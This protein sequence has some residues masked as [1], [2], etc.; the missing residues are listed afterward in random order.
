MSSLNITF[1]AAIRWGVGAVF[2]LAG[3]LASVAAA[4]VW[5]SKTELTAR[6]TT[7]EADNRS[8]KDIQL[9][10]RQD[11]KDLRQDVKELLRR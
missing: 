4:E 1:P 8:I 10:M 5:N 7:L 2:T 6:T 3:T 9:E 11:I